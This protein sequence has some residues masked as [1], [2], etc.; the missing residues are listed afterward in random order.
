MTTEFV[1]HQAKAAHDL[2][3]PRHPRG[4]EVAPC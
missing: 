3:N 1:S 2:K 4:Y